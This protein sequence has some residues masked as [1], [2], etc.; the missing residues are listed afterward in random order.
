ML[1]NE[2]R[3]SLLDALRDAEPSAGDFADAGDIPIET[4]RNREHGHYAS[5]L[6]FQLAKKLKKNPI[7]LA[8]AMAGSLSCEAVEAVNVVKPGFINISIK[9]AAFQKAMSEAIG[10]DA[11]YGRNGGGGGKKVQVEFVSANPTG[12]LSVGHGRIAAFGDCLAS[13]LDA[14]G[15]DVDREY[16][17]NNV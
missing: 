16:Y 9:P 2:L 12:P 4:P 7:K 1:V 3:K 14:S 10:R 11:E 15:Y 17:I 5:S 8:E 13:L 6:A